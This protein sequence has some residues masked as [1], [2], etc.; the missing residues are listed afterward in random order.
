V[1][2]IERQVAQQVA[3]EVNVRPRDVKVLKPGA[4]PKTS[5]GELP[6]TYAVDLIV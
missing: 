6:R 1:R 4:I 5:T 3:A 2:R